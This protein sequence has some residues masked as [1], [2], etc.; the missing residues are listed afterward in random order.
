MSKP[1]PKIK[2]S[3]TLQTNH[4]KTELKKYK[5]DC[6]KTPT[7]PPNVDRIFDNPT[8]ANGKQLKQTEFVRKA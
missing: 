1:L 7:Y 8:E 2:K 5:L 3:L 6:D 4:I